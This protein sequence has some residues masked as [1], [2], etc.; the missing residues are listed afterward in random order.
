MRT[1]LSQPKPAPRGAADLAWGLSED[2][3]DGACDGCGALGGGTFGS[4]LAC[5]PAILASKR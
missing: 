4:S 3:G 2:V 5:M 1:K